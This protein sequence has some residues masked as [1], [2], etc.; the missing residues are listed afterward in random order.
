MGLL[1]C[2]NKVEL[3]LSYPSFSPHKEMGVMG[4]FSSKGRRGRGREEEERKGWEQSQTA[5]RVF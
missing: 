2:T 3:F 1:S 5:W 4:P